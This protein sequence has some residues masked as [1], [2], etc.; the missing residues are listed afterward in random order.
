MMA[1]ATAAVAAA[2][3]LV[4]AAEVAADP[5]FIDLHIN[6]HPGDELVVHDYDGW[7]TL[8]ADNEGSQSARMTVTGQ[9]DGREGI[10]LFLENVHK[11]F[12][13]IFPKIL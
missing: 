2:I 8:G 10:Q 3:V 9:H 12:P 11:M 4:R 6:G 7:V 1:A 5:F 13:R